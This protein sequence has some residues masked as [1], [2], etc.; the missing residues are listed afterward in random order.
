MYEL[1]AKEYIFSNMRLVNV[2]SHLQ[3][4]CLFVAV[5]CIS[6]TEVPGNDKL[7]ITKSLSLSNLD[8]MQMSLLYPDV[9]KW[10]KFIAWESFSLLSMLINNVSVDELRK[11]LSDKDAY[12]NLLYSLEPVKTQN[13]VSCSSDCFLMPNFICS[14]CHVCSAAQIFI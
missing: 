14:T 1:F 13:R 10:C 7:I 8:N 12:Q 6:C 3:F 5:I 9:N 11:L 2:I 4:N